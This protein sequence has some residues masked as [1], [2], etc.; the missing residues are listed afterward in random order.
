MKSRPSFRP[1]LSERVMGLNAEPDLRRSR[2]LS[3]LRRRA[4]ALGFDAC[5]IA[6]AEA[7]DLWRERLAELLAEG[8]HGEMA[9]MAETFAR[10][11]APRD[12]WPEARSVVMLAINYGPDEDPLEATRELGKLARSRS[13]RA[14]ATITTSSRAG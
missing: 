4:L 12:L 7:P 2:F 13:M 10:R 5:R 6:P 11:A 14:I 3:E 1:L 8:R 9:W